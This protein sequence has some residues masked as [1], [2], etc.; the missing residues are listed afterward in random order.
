MS[1]EDTFKVPC[2]GC[3]ILP[4]CK[5]QYPKNAHISFLN[6]FT[7]RC[8]VLRSY[9]ELEDLNI[10]IYSLNVSTPMSKR[11]H[12]NVPLANRVIALY[13]F[14]EWDYGDT[15]DTFKILAKGEIPKGE[16]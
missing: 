11:K 6:S 2:E 13:E 3:L 8:S 5:Y 16:R 12:I 1:K 15:L 9:L 7:K 14:M 4:I 10:D